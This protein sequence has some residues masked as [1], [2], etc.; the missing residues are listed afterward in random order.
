MVKQY[1]NRREIEDLEESMNSVSDKYIK[2]D[3]TTIQKAENKLFKK[4]QDKRLESAEVFVE[5][6]KTD[7]QI[8]YGISPV[9]IYTLKPDVYFPIP[10]TDLEE[11]CNSFIDFSG[12]RNI[13][14]KTRRRHI[15]L[16]RQIFFYIGYKMRYT[17]IYL[18]KYLD[19]D[20][21]TVVY[22]KKLISDLLDI[23]NP[24]IVNKIKLIYD[25]VEKRIRTNSII[26]PNN[27]KRDNS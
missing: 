9:V 25:E 1:N 24:E 12:K 16:I 23:N 20:H 3:L 15:V 22:S 19:F 6:F 14:D 5:Q 26:Q 10:L 27:N 11:I 7:F 18:A 8:M 4:L 17:T 2:L 13:R 21:S